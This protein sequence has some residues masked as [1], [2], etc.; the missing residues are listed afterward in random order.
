MVNVG[1]PVKV[2]PL[3]KFFRYS[4]L[5][6]GIFY[7][8]SKKKAF[9]VFESGRRE[10]KARLKAERDAQ[11]ALEKKAASERDIQE[12]VS[13][14]MPDEPRFRIQDQSFYIKDENKQ[15]VDQNTS[16]KCIVEEVKRNTEAE[17]DLSPLNNYDGLK[18]NS[19]CISHPHVEQHNDTNTSS[20]NNDIEKDSSNYYVPQ[21]DKVPF[22]AG[23]SESFY[24]KDDEDD[25]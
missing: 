2:S 9:E 8:I 23:E 18:T 20:D 16:N 10:E 15:P 11:I 12:I 14:F 17:I 4:F 5:I 13:I 19:D 7:G 1:D 3:I 6:A 21:P 22:A 24:P 25:E